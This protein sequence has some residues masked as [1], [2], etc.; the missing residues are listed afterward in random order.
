MSLP[1]V[2]LTP[3]S[4]L[5]SVWISRKQLSLSAL[6]IST[7]PKSHTRTTCFPGLILPVRRRVF[8]VGPVVARVRDQLLFLRLRVYVLFTRVWNSQESLWQKCWPR[9]KRMMSQKG[10]QMGCECRAKPQQTGAGDCWRKTSTY[11]SQKKIRHGGGV[12][13]W[14]TELLFGG[15]NTP[16]RT[17]QQ[18]RWTAEPRCG[19]L[20]LYQAI[21]SSEEPSDQK[22]WNQLLPKTFITNVM[23]IFIK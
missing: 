22:P 1:R 18:E 13:L 2:G 23:N 12:S 7:T 4:S 14:N 6:D 3:Q 9:R 11:T 16:I 20:L 19:A 21:K 17:Q 10:C 5:C 15:C 8:S